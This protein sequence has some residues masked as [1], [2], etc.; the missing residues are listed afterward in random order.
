MTQSQDGR[1]GS[2][3]APNSVL[4]RILTSSVDAA[5]DLQDDSV[6]VTPDT[7]PGLSVLEIIRS[8]S[9]VAPA[10]S[11][12]TNRVSVTVNKGDTLYAIAKRHG[13]KVSELAGLNGLEEPF[14]IKVGQTLYIA[15]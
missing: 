4:D 5:G 12:G 9:D 11:S 14:I 1:S 15:R 2:E 13:L 3:G 10:V 6:N 8:N 7:K